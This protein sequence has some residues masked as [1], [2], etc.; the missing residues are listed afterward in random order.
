M[1]GPDLVEGVVA[2]AHNR[3]VLGHEAR[4]RVHVR[5]VAGVPFQPRQ[6]PIIFRP[7]PCSG[8]RGFG[9]GMEGKGAMSGEVGS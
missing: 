6:I 9:A 4:R 1:K 5:E 2:P 3:A 7:A 8:S